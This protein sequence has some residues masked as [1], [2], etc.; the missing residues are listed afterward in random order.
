MQIVF[1]YSFSTSIKSSA[2]ESN[3]I[4]LNRLVTQLDTY[5][6]SMEQIIENIKNENKV[7]EYLKLSKIENDEISRDK[8]EREL[9]IFHKARQ[10]GYRV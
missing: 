9:Q 2:G 7:L 6:E 5:V 10:P 4:L 1:Y 8:I 3:K